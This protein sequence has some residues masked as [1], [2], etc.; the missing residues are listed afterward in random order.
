MWVSCWRQSRRVRPERQVRGAAEEHAGGCINPMAVVQLAAGKHWG[1]ENRWSDTMG[2]KPGCRRIKGPQWLWWDS[3]EI[4]KRGGWSG[5]VPQGSLKSAWIRARIESVSRE[6]GRGVAGVQASGFSKWWAAV[7]SQMTWGLPASEW[8]RLATLRWD[9]RAGY[10]A[11]TARF[12]PVQSQHPWSRASSQAVSPALVLPLTGGQRSEG[13]E[14]VEA[15]NGCLP[16]DRLNWHFLRCPKR[17][18][19][20]ITLEPRWRWRRRSGLQGES[21]T[22]RSEHLREAVDES[23]NWIQLPG[24]GS[25]WCLHSIFNTTITAPA[26]AGLTQS[27]AC[28]QPP[29]F[30][31]WSI[32]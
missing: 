10:R 30:T 5:A 15:E 32:N 13:G 31:L 7:K 11:G 4:G 21:D 1:S 20:N 2:L 24:L 26:Y 14:L 6:Q 12:V 25:P 28:A 17:G 29:A 23:R 19:S 9:K 27:L 22:G 18:N 8:S 3:I 16:L